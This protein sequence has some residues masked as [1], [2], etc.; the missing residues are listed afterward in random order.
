M[1]RRETA[2]GRIIGEEKG[3]QGKR[4]GRMGKEGRE[5]KNSGKREV[6]GS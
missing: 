2:M 3:E 1:E 5:G 6:G 4:R